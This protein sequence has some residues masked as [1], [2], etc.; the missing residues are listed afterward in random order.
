MHRHGLSW[1]L[2]QGGLFQDKLYEISYADV[3]EEHL[4]NQQN[5][6]EISPGYLRHV[7]TRDP[8][9]VDIFITRRLGHGV[10]VFVG[11]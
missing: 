7:G 1:G 11:L 9:R 10:G 4:Y 6:G 5:R 8:I 2:R 3:G